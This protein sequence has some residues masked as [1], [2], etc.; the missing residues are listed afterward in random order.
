MTLN[1]MIKKP[2]EKRSALKRSL[3]TAK[4]ATVAAGLGAVLGAAAGMLSAPKKGSDL[5]RDTAR[6]AVMLKKRSLA[7]E[8]EFDRGF[9]RLSP[10]AQSALRSAKRRLVKELATAKERLTKAHYHDMVDSAFTV[11]S[12]GKKELSDAAAALTS[13]WKR[14][15][16]RLKK[17]L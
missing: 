9:K 2:D 14:S 12:K 3:R 16:E 1:N 17:H 11:A 13:E 5:R 7:A 10:E 4:I 15:Y 6:G 8:R